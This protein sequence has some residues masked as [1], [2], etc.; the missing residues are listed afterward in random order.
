LTAG[1]TASDAAQVEPRPA[2]AATGEPRPDT[3]QQR[4]RSRG[5]FQIVGRLGWGVADQAIASLSNFALGLY[6]AR[7]FGAASFGAFSLAFITYTVVL[8]AARGTATDPM[9]VRYSGAVRRPWRRAAASASGTV[10]G[11]GVVL[12]LVCVGV[13]LLLPGP[14]GPAFVG[15]GIV[16]PGLLLQDSWRFAFF[17]EGR[18][19]RAFVNDLVW[20]VLLVAALVVLHLAGRGGVFACLLAFGGTAGVAAGVGAFQAGLLPRPRLIAGWLREHRQLSARYLVE[21]VTAS[22]AAQLR[23][24]VLGAVS[25]LASVGYVR[26][27][28]ILMG[29]FSVIL[30]GV[31][32]VA[33]PEA[34]TV[35]R[36]AAHRL[37][38]FCLALGGV[39]AAGALLWGVALLTLLPLGPGEFLLKELWHPTSQ[40]L[41][42]VILN[43]V[44][45]C[46]CT[47]AAAGLR[48]MGVA[49]RSLRAQL[50]TSFAYVVGGCVGAVL[51][52]AQG[53]VWGVAAANAVGMTAWWLQL[54]AALRDHLGD[55]SDHGLDGKAVTA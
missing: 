30:M 32:Q 46:F 6:V 16:L 17:A 2:H 50:I 10:L 34:S 22:G 40:L 47:S 1:N 38:R 41:P 29:P 45:G 11:M 52:G 53:T 43:V 39:Q 8:N 35:F 3:T 55:G 20:T 42:A 19:A 48:A 31:A 24:V 18:P 28:E 21:N 36:Q 54:N 15:L 33:V 14:V 26:G 7:T 44:E 13:G 51:G 4:V 25:G 37:R 49:K 9:M 5:L 12:G 27:A 23:S